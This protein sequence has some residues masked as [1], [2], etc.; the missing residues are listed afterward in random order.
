MSPFNFVFASLISLV[1]I[2]F[3]TFIAVNVGLV[4]KPNARKNHNGEVPLVG[5]ISIFCSLA[6][7]S[8]FFNVE[9][10]NISLF[11]ML[12]SFVVIIGVLDDL[13]DLSVLFRL[14][15]QFSV[16]VIFVFVGGYEISYLGTYFDNK[17][18]LDSFAPLFTILAVVAAI[19]MFNMID[20]IDGLLGVMAAN[21]FFYVGIL[22]Y[23]NG[24]FNLA[25][26]PLTLCCTLIPFLLLNVFGSHSKNSKKVFMGD[27][28]S[29]FMGFAVVWLLVLATQDAYQSPVIS[30]VV[31]LWLIAVPLMDMVAI[32]FRR[33]RKGQ[34]PFKSD[35]EHLHHIF[36][37]LGFSPRGALWVICLISII[38]STFG[39]AMHNLGI[40]D[41]WLICVY[42]ALFGLYCFIIK[43]IWRII[44]FLNRL[45]SKS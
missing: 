34:S 16:A 8:I 38:M 35:R 5:G 32:M 6:V 26:V 25:V 33:L 10:P 41:H 15:V 9:F 40:A 1:L 43:R 13:F 39:V 14:V 7:C 3:F 27:G 4:D 19:N 18:Y 23:L 31:A 29:M 2:Q 12:M 30:P 21:A 20:G 44:I 37:R 42:I 24:N 22:F 45:T 36:L 11:L 17:I 28:G